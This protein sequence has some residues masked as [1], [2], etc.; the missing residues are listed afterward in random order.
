MALLADAE[1]K[2]R[3]LGKLALDHHSGVAATVKAQTWGFKTENRL[4]KVT[5]QSG[6][7]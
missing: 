6:V 7:V 4:V 3:F 2:V 1:L 5:I